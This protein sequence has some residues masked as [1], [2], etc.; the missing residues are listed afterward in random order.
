M[1]GNILYL[2]FVIR[3]SYFLNVVQRFLSSLNILNFAGVDDLSTNKIDHKSLFADIPVENHN[4]GYDIV[5]N[6][7]MDVSI[8]NH[9]QIL[10]LYCLQLCLRLIKSL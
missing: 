5:P 8:N 6:F 10:S 4:Y 1:Y 2:R 9:L 7:G 3:S